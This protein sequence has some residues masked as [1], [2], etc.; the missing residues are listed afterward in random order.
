MKRV[1]S[2]LWLEFG[3]AL[4]SKFIFMETSCFWGTLVSKVSPHT[5]ISKRSSVYAHWL[6]DGICTR[7]LQRGGRGGKNTYHDRHHDRRGKNEQLTALCTGQSESST[8]CQYATQ[9]KWLSCIIR[10][11]SFQMHKLTPDKIE[12]LL[13]GASIITWHFISWIWY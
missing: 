3:H 13:A 10:L 8:L 7:R 12:R 2:L 4:F 5:L 9:L 11:T 1:Y 6:A